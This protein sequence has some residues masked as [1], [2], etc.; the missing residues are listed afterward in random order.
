MYYFRKALARW[1]KSSLKIRAYPRRY[2]QLLE[3]ID[4]LHPRTILEIG[5]NDGRNAARLFQRAAHYRD[6]VEYFGFDLFESMNDATFLRE[7]S[8]AAPDQEKVDS[9]L[10]RNGVLRRKLFSGNTIE[11]LHKIKPQLPKMDFVFIDGG[12][13]QETVA[14]DWAN[15]QDLLHPQS[16]VFFDDYPNWGVGPVVD[17]IDRSRWDVR[18]LPI[19]DVFRVNRRFDPDSVSGHMTFKCARV[20]SAG[21]AAQ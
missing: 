14:S 20:R 19:S 5:T 3:E 21:R 1:L 12:H 16:V 7:F 4:T 17:A 9:F 8:L 15:V 18:I 10:A 6:D 2:D 13:S 11:S